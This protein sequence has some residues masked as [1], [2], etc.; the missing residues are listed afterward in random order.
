MLNAAVPEFNRSAIRPLECVSEGWQLIKRDYW[1]MCGICA[2]GLIIG[3]AGP[4]GLLLGPLMSGIHLCVFALGRAEKP[5][6]SL[7]F[8]G[9][10]YFLP[11][12]VATLIKI[13]PVMIVIVPV[14]ILA[15]ALGIGASAFAQS[16][17]ADPET[18]VIAIGVVAFLILAIILVI[19]MLVGS[20]F[21]FS[22]QLVV[23]RGLNGVDACKLSARAAVANAGGVLGL[24]LLT[25][26]MGFAGL[27]ACYVGAFLV[28]PISFAALDV[29]YRRVFPPITRPPVA[30]PAAPPQF[31]NYGERFPTGS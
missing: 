7:L 15:I 5:S 1:L 11:S 31:P 6:F 10:D 18:F 16:N 29:A 4:F 26:V 2:V 21:L 30:P 22:Y 19:S 13:I 23:D 25:T 20:L 3:G 12:L 28:V 14:Y 24:V 8:K 9:F 27:L 17:H